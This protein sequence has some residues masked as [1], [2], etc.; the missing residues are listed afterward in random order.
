MARQW[1][2]QKYP[3]AE[4]VSLAEERLAARASRDFARADALRDQI[5]ALGFG[6]RDTPQGPQVVPLDG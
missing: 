6:V 1:L 4:V 3:G 5:A 2:L